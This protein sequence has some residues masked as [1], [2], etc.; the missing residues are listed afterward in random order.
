MHRIELRYCTPTLMDGL[1]GSGAVSQSVTLPK[2]GD[3]SLT[4]GPATLNTAV[5]SQ[6]PIGAAFHRCDRDRVHGPRRDGPH[7]R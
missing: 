4:I 1:S 7:S 2:S 6:V 5:A 3:T